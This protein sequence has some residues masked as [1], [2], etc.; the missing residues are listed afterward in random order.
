MSRRFIVDTT[1]D[2]PGAAR[3][4]VLLSAAVLVLGGAACG[5][6]SRTTAT[7]AGTGPTTSTTTA[8]QTTTRPTSSVT[9]GPVQGKLTAD[10][11][12]PVVKKDWHYSL[13]VTNASGHPLSGTVD[14]EFVF[15]GVVVGHDSPPT[16]PVT[17]GRWH[18]A[19]QFPADSVGEPLIFQAVV[20]TSRGSIT[21]D[22]PITVR[23]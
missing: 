21:L 7:T 12:S 14:I 1:R 18:D 10:N 16:H 2:V 3:L 17:N 8:T 23:Q 22:W 6:R 13:I 5:G 11:H 9:T 19:L 15:G 20:H 4:A